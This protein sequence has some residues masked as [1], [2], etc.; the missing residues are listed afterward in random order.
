MSKRWIQ[1][2][3]EEI[4]MSVFK[5]FFTQKGGAGSGPEEGHEFRGNQYTG[6][7][8][9]GA[10]ASGLYHGTAEANVK[11]ILESGLKP[12]VG[13]VVW[14]TNDQEKALNYAM[15][16]T[17][18]WARE[19]GIA[20]DKVNDLSVA[21]IIINP[22]GETIGSS[23]VKAVSG[24]V[25]PEDIIRVELYKYGDIGGGGKAT[26]KSVLKKGANTSKNEVFVIVPPDI[27]YRQKDLQS[28]AG[29]KK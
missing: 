27:L 15:L 17:K 4:D 13:N 21:L 6:G 3:K 8:G 24:R 5:G 14:A 25:P 16:R 7:I 18:S 20:D 22:K 1:Y 28:L 19:K 26:P 9:E 10:E 2:K 29:T 23:Q 12:S 11:N